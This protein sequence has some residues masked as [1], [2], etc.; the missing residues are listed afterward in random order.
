M[1]QT[2][3]R[4][5]PAI[6]GVEPRDEHDLRIWSPIAMWL[7]GAC[8]IGVGTLLPDG[9]TMQ[10][11]QLRGLVG[12]G[13]LAAVFTFFAFQPASNRT[14]YILTNIFSALGAVTV[15]LAC[16]W[17][18][19]PSSGFAE[20]YFFPILYDAY[21]FRP[22]HL[23]WHLIFVSGLALSPLFYAASI[24]GTQFP[25]HVAM[26]VSG[27]WG[28][29]AV[30]AYRKHRLMQAEMA[31]RK[32]A[33]SDPLTGVHNLRSLRDRAEARPLTHGSAVLVI[34]IDDFKGVNTEYGHTGADEL[35][36]QVALDLVELSDERDCVARI[37][38]D[39]FAILIA[40]KTAADVRALRT[41]CARAIRST[42]ARA[43]LQGRDLSVS[44]GYAFSPKDGRT[45][46][47]LLDAAD[48]SMFSAKA[49]K[50]A[51]RGAGAVLPAPGTVAPG[52]PSGISGP[53]PRLA[54]ELRREI[55]PGGHS[56]EGP[57]N[58]W[59]TR[60]LRSIAAASAWVTASMAAL[61]VILLPGADRSH[62]SLVIALIVCST[63]VGVLTLLVAPA[64]G[65]AAYAVSDML[66]VPVIGLGVYL[67]G[68][69]TSPLLPLVF[70]AVTFAAYFGTPR[71]AVI[72][73]AGAVA[74]CASPFAYADG[75][76]RLQFIVRFV[77]LVTT[78]AVL[79]GIILYNRRELAQ[80]EEASLDLASHD[81]LT[82]LPNRRAFQVSLGTALERPADRLA[83]A[84]IDLDN[85]KQVN[86]TH[87]HAAGDEVLQ[88]IAG[89]LGSATRPEDCVARIGGDEFALVARD[90]DMSVARA[91]SARCVRAVEEAVAGAGY[92]DCGVSA[93]VGFALHPHH[94]I[95]LDSLLEAADSALMHA[96]EKGKRRVGCAP[97][98]ASSA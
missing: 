27:L 16:L 49:G 74:I 19:G 64:V 62:L 45:L 83:V 37:G 47:E 20:M 40:G 29:S 82:G 33:L 13:L 43:G 78:A 44:I 98:R 97:A 84:M 6:R 12:F 68:G 73:L 24:R 30:V 61:A 76:A 28:M 48:R 38:G 18:G 51:E 75:D 21:F 4:T 59:P 85:F 32:Q 25:G 9:G 11:D 92:Q 23:V 69:T 3:E 77:A 81:P 26:L 67:T 93:T 5:T 17:S 89:A 22:R 88:A 8:A 79:V 94:G 36:R 1:G 54:T 66:A 55:D 58:W 95:T 41:R 56:G 90:A 15:F 87:G 10:I 60:P 71:G 46:H 80:A 2:I 63:A 86:D 34:D 35:L 31:S 42:R 52:E 96:K 57:P 72:R 91:L 53:H 7:A 39:E 14:L 50:R 65:E 70:L